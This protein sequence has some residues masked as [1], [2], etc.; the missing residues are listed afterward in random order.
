[1]HKMET[2]GAPNHALVG[3]RS[4]RA[5]FIAALADSLNNQCGFAAGKLG[6]SEQVWLSSQWLLTEKGD[7]PRLQQAIRTSRRFHACQ[8]IG[9]FPSTNEYLDSTV[10]GFAESVKNMDFLAVHDSP[11]VPGIS[12]ELDLNAGLLSFSDIEPNKDTPYNSLDCYLPSFR[13]KR[14]LIVTTPADLLVSR[15]NKETF[16]STWQKIDMPWFQPQSVEALPF[17]SLFDIDINNVYSTSLEVFKD[18]SHE[19]S[20][21]DFDIALIAAGSLGIPLAH[22]VKNLGKV[23]LSL[24][25]HLQV[26]FGVQGKRWRENPHWQ[27]AY[28]N[29]SWIDMPREL[30]PRG[31]A[32]RADDG[33]YW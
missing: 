16:E 7:N 13:D 32:W 19:I 24:G 18:I 3:A 17:V 9:V 12:R 4:S 20:K 8:Q 10:Q 27:Q 14:I 21:R 6:Y 22:H 15:A 23:G 28:W 26:I 5:T 1:M 25:G 29:E 33:A 31:T 30:I 2:K 11:L